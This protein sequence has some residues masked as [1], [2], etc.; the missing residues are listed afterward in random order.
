MTVTPIRLD[1]TARLWRLA[2]RSARL[3][4]SLIYSGMFLVLGTVIVVLIF[5][6]GTGQSSVA[7]SSASAAPVG[8]AGATVAHAAATQQ[9]TADVNRLLGGAWITL[10]LTAVISAPLG[11]FV[12]G[13]M[14]RPLRQ[15]SLAAQAISAGS[16]HQ[17][18][19]LTG[20]DDEFKQLGDTIDDL[21]GR[22][23][24]SFATQRRFVANAAHEL[25]TP[26][27]VERA[28]LQVALADPGADTAKLR[29]TCE[30]LIAS[31]REQERLLD[32]LLTLATSERGLDR[33]DVIDLASVIDV[34]LAG[35]SAAAEGLEII[36]ELEPV[37]I[38]GDRAL[39]ERLV[40]NLIDNA[41]GYNRPG[42]RIEVRTH[43]LSD[44]AV[45]TVS[46]TGERIASEQVDRLFEPFRR[47]GSDRTG[48]DGHH[49]LGLSIV[50]AVAQAHQAE[51]AAIPVPGGG[52]TVTVTFPALTG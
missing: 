27:T 33:R 41:I 8:A 23:E 3:R 43:S 10:V 36:T 47:L 25:R 45:L 26:L 18:L 38:S 51:V 15:M 37:L 48:S 6:I 5:A 34:A 12:A 24:S 14:L 11:W 29:A 42:G 2:P 39:T 19:A 31:G 22:L 49:G 7:A 32:A 35:A 44:R 16:L 1:R 21:L 52:L 40:H 20:A 4:L 17:R 9:H 30:E 50:R 13:R 46:N 28:L